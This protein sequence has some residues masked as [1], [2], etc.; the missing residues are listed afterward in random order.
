MLDGVRAILNVDIDN[1]DEQDEDEN[2]GRHEYSGHYLLGEDGS[3]SLSHVD[4][5]AAP[6]IDVSCDGHN[7]FESASQFAAT[8]DSEDGE[9]NVAI[10]DT[11]DLN[12]TARNDGFALVAH[13]NGMVLGGTP[14]TQNHAS[15]TDDSGGRTDEDD[16][17]LEDGPD[18]WGD[19][20]GESRWGRAIGVGMG[21]SD[22]SGPGDAGVGLALVEALG[23]WCA[24]VSA[25]DRLVH[26]APGSAAQ[27]AE[28]AETEWDE[29]EKRIAR[30]TLDVQLE[31]FRCETALS[32]T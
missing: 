9:G 28:E 31:E 4:R 8:G 6:G 26:L 27:R 24:S 10:V 2:S 11:A 20:R 21:T 30:S 19:G 18:P 17:D 14:K 16:S 22:A 25:Y 12:R 3:H 13:D 23:A 1:S 5:I 32:N 15:T 7:S 29:L